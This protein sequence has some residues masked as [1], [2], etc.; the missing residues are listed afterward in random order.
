MDQEVEGGVFNSPAE[1]RKELGADANTLTDEYAWQIIHE[2][3]QEQERLAKNSQEEANRIKQEKEQEALR[4]RQEKDQELE[5]LKR[6]KDQELERVKRDKDQEL[7]RVKR[8]KESASKQL[9][10]AYGLQSAR[11]EALRQKNALQLELEL[12]R[13][14]LAD[15]L[16]THDAVAR[17]IDR[18]NLKRELKAEMRRSRPRS[19]PR[20]Q[21]KA[22]PKSRTRSKS[23]KRSGKRWKYNLVDTVGY[24]FWLK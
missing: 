3:L 19:R 20:P 4:I 17:L 8:E 5:R 7:E 15:P 21:T 6:D 22:R 2:G 9:A 16:R 23:K 14:R 12:E 1:M 13:R 10:D 24:L 18:E 11:D